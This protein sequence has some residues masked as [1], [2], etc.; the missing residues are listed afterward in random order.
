MLGVDADAARAEA[1][2]DLAAGDTVVLY[3]DGLVE[4]RGRYARRRAGPALRARRRAR[5]PAAG[6]SCATRCSSGC[7]RAVPQD[8]V[9]V[10]AVTLER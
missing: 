8:D 1:S 3:T 5:R 10:A 9:A 7:C 2:V 4:R 6:A